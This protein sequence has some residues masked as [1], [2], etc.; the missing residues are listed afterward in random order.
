MAKHEGLGWK[1]MEGDVVNEE[2]DGVQTSTLALSLEAL[3]KEE[4]MTA[5]TEFDFF[6]FF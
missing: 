3:N 4:A 1:K 6:I 2:G 5:A